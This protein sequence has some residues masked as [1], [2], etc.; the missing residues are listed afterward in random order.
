M[1]ENQTKKANLLEF[2]II[3]SILNKNLKGKNKNEMNVLLINPWIYDFAAYDLW[4]KPLGLLRIA[5]FLEEFGHK[6]YLLNCLDRHHIL[7]KNY[8]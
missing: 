1:T 4:V 7:L 6:V 3:C 8:K 5:S 2:I